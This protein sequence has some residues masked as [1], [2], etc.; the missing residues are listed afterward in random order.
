MT[1]EASKFELVPVAELLTPRTGREVRVDWWWAVTEDDKVP[2]YVGDKGRF[3]TYQCNQDRRVVEH[4]PERYPWPIR[5]V[6]LPVAY[7]PPRD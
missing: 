4:R 1:I 2:V 3:R 7:L 6:Q 5:A